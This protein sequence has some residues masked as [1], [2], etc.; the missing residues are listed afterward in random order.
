[1]VVFGV[2]GFYFWCPAGL[3]TW[4]SLWGEPCHPAAGGTLL[5]RDQLSRCC[6]SPPRCS[7]LLCSTS[8]LP[9]PENSTGEQQRGHNNSLTVTL[10]GGE[11]TERYIGTF[12]ETS[13]KH[14]SSYPL[15]IQFHQLLSDFGCVECQSEA[16]QIEFREK[17]LQYVFDGQPP[18]GAVLRSG[19]HYIL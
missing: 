13:G 12:C 14:F 16:G 2:L 11:G 19:R 18:C 15:F 6:T 7:D 9:S 4:W 5:G 10:K 8:P 1:M 3:C 17:V